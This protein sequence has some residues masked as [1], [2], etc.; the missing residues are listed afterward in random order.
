MR[1]IAV[2]LL[3]GLACVAPARS[4]APPN[5]WYP[6][7][8]KA[9]NDTLAIALAKLRSASAGAGTA[10]SDRI[11]RYDIEANGTRIDITAKIHGFDYALAAVI[12]GK[13]IVFGRNGGERWRATAG[14]TVHLI[15]ADVQGDYL[16]RW[17]VAALGFD[18][19]DCYLAGV[20]TLPRP[21]WVI[22]DQ[23]ALETPHWLYV[24]ME[25]GDVVREVSREGGRTETFVFSDIRGDPGARRSYRWT[26]SG[27]GGM[28]NVT[29]S[30][31]T[32]A[33]LTAADV[34]VPAQGPPEFP[35]PVAERRLSATINERNA[36][37][38]SVRVNGKDRSFQL[39]SGTPELILS[40]DVSR[41]SGPI[42]LGHGIADS[43]D[44]DDQI[45]RDAPFLDVDFYEDGVLG[46]DFFRGRIVHVD[47]ARGRVDVLPRNG[48]VPP[49]G[50]FSMPTDW[51]EGMPLVT[52]QIGDAQGSR[53]VL[54]IGSPRLVLRAAFVKAAGG[55]TGIDVSHGRT[56]TIR[57]LEG[58]FAI[59]SGKVPAVRFGGVKIAN[60]PVFVEVPNADNMDFPIDGIIGTEELA[61]FEWWFDADGTT[62]WFAPRK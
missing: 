10:V 55:A 28:A 13:T 7:D 57:Y 24:D 49:T 45:A 25:S 18:V 36:I 41:A 31:A 52:A 9:S 47:Y 5:T 19:A 6:S 50:A 42:V 17:P 16:D 44:V 30:K 22:A 54:D 35:A 27:P 11:D 39:D 14:G 12:A 59:K 61:L 40:D 33:R 60:E 37:M 21:A 15:R 56:S 23:P 8:I 20:A 4:Q 2:V 43:L 48:F 62:T 58:P 53:F 29:L 46:F 34:A 38:M 3:L 1:R 51:S 32:R 26:V